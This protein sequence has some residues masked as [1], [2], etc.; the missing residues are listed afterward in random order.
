MNK[1]FNDFIRYIRCELNLSVHT[2]SSYSIDISQWL[3]FAAANYLACNSGKT[4]DIDH[5][6]VTVADIRLWI[7]F[8]A[9]E[10]IS[11]RTIRHKVQALR[12]FYRFMIRRGI[13]AVNPA[14]DITTARLPKSLPVF[15]RPD[16][17]RYCLDE[18]YDADNFVEVRDRLIVTM[19]Y[20]TGMRAAE[21]VNL[22]DA[23]VDT[24]RCE[25]KVLGKRNKE[26]LIPFGKELQEMI[27]LYRTLRSRE[28]PGCAPAEF[29]VR[30]SGEP[31][32]YALVNKAVHKMLD[33]RVTATRRT[34][35]VLRHSCA[36]DLLNNGAD[37]T[38]VQRLLGHASLA[39]TQIYTHLSIRDLQNNYKLAHPRAQKQ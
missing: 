23:D 16:E 26:R 12:A 30:P 5:A 20:S 19:F 9:N 15:V 24:K 34:P 7:A 27:D 3:R 2:V 4:Q 13:L 11:Q 32:Y 37:L 28:I 1:L 6:A 31:L 8:L 21:L 29:F 36:T 14:A 33:G 10:D 22:L 38:A 18:P 25:L 39:T 17:T 35:H